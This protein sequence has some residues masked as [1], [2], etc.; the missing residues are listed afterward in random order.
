[1][2]MHHG[3]SPLLRKDFQ[4]EL[5]IDLVILLGGHNKDNLCDL[6]YVLDQA[7]PI[8]LLKIEWSH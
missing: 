4:R 6:P 5:P 1:M 2:W 8:S 3:S 7:T